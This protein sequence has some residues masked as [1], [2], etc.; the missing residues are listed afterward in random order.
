VPVKEIGFH[1]LQNAPMNEKERAERNRKFRVAR[2]YAGL[3]QRAFAQQVGVDDS[4]VSK[5]LKGTRRSTRIE[6]AMQRL[7]DRHYPKDS[8]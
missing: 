4:T 8:A 6:A 3:T 7:I 1:N 2:A 5:V